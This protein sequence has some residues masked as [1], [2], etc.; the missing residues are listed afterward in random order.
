MA[1]FVKVAA[2][3]ELDENSVKGVKIGNKEIAL[4]LEN[5]EVYATSD[6]CTHEY[7]IIHENFALHGEEVE[8]TCHGSHY[9]IKTGEN[10]LP[11]SAEPLPVYK[12]K[13]ENGEVFVEI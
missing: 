2:L 4:F 10:T 5:G 3:S 13:V 8:C 7:C 6:L 11:P 1:D 12:T 9:N